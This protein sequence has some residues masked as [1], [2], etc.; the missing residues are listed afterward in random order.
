MKNKIFDYIEKNKDE[1]FGS[2]CEMI[3]INTENFGNRG[4]EKPLALY[5]EKKLK[6]IGINSDIY[7][8]DEV[9]GIMD[10]ED[11]L[12][13]RN[14][15]DRTNITAMLKGK[16]GKKSLMLAAHLDTMPIGDL[17][18][19]TVNPTEGIIKD[20]KIWGRGACD[21]KYAIATWL[22][23]AKMFK[24]LNIELENDIYFTGY[25]DEEFGG[26]DGALASV[27]KYPCDL[28]I[29]LDSKEYEIWHCASGGQEIEIVLKCKD[30]QD[31]CQKVINGLY[32]A[33]EKLLE[34][35]ERR[36]EELNKNPFYKKTIIP[37][38]SMRI[39]KMG[40]GLEG[41]D[42]DVGRIRFVYYTDKSS[43]EIKKEYEIL[44]DEIN[45]GLLPLDME[46]KDI[47]YVSRLFRYGWADPNEENIKLFKDVGNTISNR[48][49]NI[50]GSCLSDLSL[51]LAN[52]EKTAFAFGMG[53]DFSEYGGAHQPDEY[54][55][56]DVLIE[57]TKI[58]AQFIMDWDKNNK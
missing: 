29:N 31:S 51:F 48:E 45:K 19:W 46:I 11:Y 12:P 2:L 38:T 54:I 28:Y 17:K 43:C 13:G 30:A 24:E 49:I 15:E 56:C 55:E 50:C 39:L 22:F 1:L 4:N 26:G 18:L 25:V 32:A 3:S 35:Q 9:E 42:M 14:L 20:G 53:R 41:N 6:E 10:K 23:L 57:F 8:P 44:F 27:V 7:S 37:D 34:F 21:D 58:L 5:L 47:V 16:N 33:K 40:C 52:T 36:K